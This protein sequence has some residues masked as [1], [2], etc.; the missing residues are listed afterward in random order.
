MK[1]SQKL[2]FATVVLIATNLSAQEIS[3]YNNDKF[4]P[5][6]RI[7][8]RPGLNIHTSVRTYQ[9]DKINAI[10]NIDSL[11][12]DGLKV[13]SG[14]LN[15]WQRIFHD[16][17]LKW[18]N[19]E[20]TIKINPLFDFGVGNETDEGKGTWNNTRGL[21]I[22][23]TFGKNFY[24]YTDFVENQ[25]VFPNYMDEFVDLRKVVP[26]QGKSK[27]YGDNAHDYAQSTGFIS[28]NPAKWFNVQLG[29][30]KH[31]I[32]DGY[33]SLLLSDNSFSYPYLK[34]S[35]EFNKVH[36]HVLWA[37]HR[38]LNNITEEQE[39]NDSRY[40]DKYSASHYLTINVGNRLSMGLF[41]S[42]V[43]AGQDNRGQR[44][45]D[46]SYLN[47]II[48]FRP[49][50]YSLGSPDNMTMGLT[51]K[52]IV[53]NNSALY[54]QFV[55]GEFK[56]DEVFSGNK[57]WA[58][59]QGFQL[60]FKSYNLFGINKLDFL[61]EYNQVR[62]YTYSHRETITNYAHYNQELAHPLGANFR[63]SVTKVKYQYRRFVFNAELMFAMYGKDLSDDEDAPSFGQNIFRDNDY[64]PE[65]YGNSI[66]QGLRT[67]LTYL[68]GN[69]SYL[70]NPRNNFNIAAGL[71]IR[72]ESNDQETKNTQMV[73][74]A[75][76][77]SI[78]S[79]YTDF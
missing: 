24:F 7:I 65:D 28:F 31:F 53:G 6:E 56:F 2:I 38:D 3:H 55:L 27:S 9:L 73:W 76:R 47:P 23:G 61:T 13:P 35:A 58:N 44:N 30:G 4:N 62:P 52:Y 51:T 43:W 40:L 18:E 39:S 67:N 42:V 10:T 1:I 5:F 54:G 46:L 36:Y 26:G 12:Y 50:E 25:S 71:R 78:R 15:F 48:F 37:Q 17:L 16:D 60:G 59:K 22:E 11:L 41:E 49:L 29:Q 70:I 20:V 32:G 79:I 77:T 45:F 64:R 72:K 57:W 63:E 19:E 74:F 68:D 33:R 34:F 14:K 21:F 8:Y 66:G 75:V 69:M